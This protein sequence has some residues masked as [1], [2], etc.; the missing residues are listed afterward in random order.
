M[1]SARWSFSWRRHSATVSTAAFTPQERA[2][3]VAI[4]RDA[5]KRDPSILRDAIVVLQADNDRIE[6]QARREVLTNRQDQLFSAND[7]SV[8]NP[9][10]T[11]TIVEFYDPRSPYWRRSWHASSLKTPT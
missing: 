4:V 11:T 3:V 8:G 6:A 5:L 1:A 2:Q 10:G 9:R 7:P